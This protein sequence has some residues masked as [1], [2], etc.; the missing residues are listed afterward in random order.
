[1]NI[2]EKLA[3]KDKVRSLEPEIDKICRDG[4][5][6]FGRISISYL[7]RKLKYSYSACEEIYN[8]FMCATK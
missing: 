7:M 2:D 1:M 3:V 5:L 4:V 6:K 8:T